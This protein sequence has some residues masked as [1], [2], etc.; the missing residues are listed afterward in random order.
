[1]SN[2][3]VDQT[4]VSTE[5]AARTRLLGRRLIL[6]FYAAVRVARFHTVANDATQAA[7]DRLVLSFAPLFELHYDVS[8]LFYSRDFYVNDTRIKATREDYD[9]FEAFAGDLEKREIGGLQFTMPPTPEGL[10][11]FILAF[12]EVRPGKGDEPY[13]EMGRRLQLAGAR[14]IV[15]TKYVGGEKVEDLPVIDKRTFARQSYFRAISIA[16]QL[17]TQARQRKP[18]ALKSAKRVVQNFVD[19]LDDPNAEHSDLLILLTQ[20]KNWQGYLFNHAVN[21]CVLSLALGDA[22]GLSRDALRELGIAALLADVGNALLDEDVL[23][24]PNPLSDAQWAQ[25]RTHP[26]RGVSAIAA[27]QE[28]DR[29]LMRATTACLWHQRNYD[30]SGYPAHIQGRPGLFAQIIAVCDQFDAMTTPR[31][32]RPRSMT[33]PRA[34][35]SL[36][37]GA[38]KVFNPLIVRAFVQHMGTVPAGTV[39]LLPTGEIGLVMR[40]RS[41]LREG[42]VTRIRVLMQGSG[43]LQA[44]DVVDLEDKAAGRQVMQVIGATDEALHNLKANAI[45]ADGEESTEL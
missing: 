21:T 2:A 32:Y 14:G 13:Q 40:S 30:G 16:Q 17:Y 45:L 33:P 10:S 25:I 42:D 41:Q 4:A 35:E 31:P 19:L 3:P 27:F 5:V 9:V 20:V 36:A 29:P 39:V 7:I 44:D 34:L 18:L 26:V 24:S 37:R 43:S 6:D 38:G 8:I 22:M 1:M 15:L 12:N 28:M 11:E 23:D